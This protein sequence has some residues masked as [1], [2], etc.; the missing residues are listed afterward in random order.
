MLDRTILALPP[1][2][3]E[4]D[5]ELPRTSAGAPQQGLWIHVA[6]T[7]ARVENAALPSSALLP[8]TARGYLHT[9]RAFGSRQGVL[10]S[11]IERAVSPMRPS[12]GSSYVCRRPP[13]NLGVAIL[14]S[15]H[16]CVVVFGD[17][18][19]TMRVEARGALKSVT[20]SAARHLSAVAPGAKAARVVVNA[21]LVHDERQRRLGPAQSHG[22]QK[23]VFQGQIRK[24]VA[25]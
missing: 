13:P 21:H 10:Q 7:W 11:P 1:S 25:S 18:V 22:A 2:A 14:P 17:P 3:L 12:R 19:S 15:A 8:R 4:A 9:T 23:A 16:H 6:L 20:S 24:I 5:W